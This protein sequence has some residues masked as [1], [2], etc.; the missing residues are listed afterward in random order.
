Q[1][2]A[3]QRGAALDVQQVGGAFR[4]ACIVGAA[5]TFDSVALAGASVAP[6]GAGGP[7]RLLAVTPWPS[8]L[9]SVLRLPGVAARGLPTSPEAA[10]WRCPGRRPCRPRRP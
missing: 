5:H 8:G 7:E 3:R 4:H 6:A 9:A 2:A 1:R 10:T